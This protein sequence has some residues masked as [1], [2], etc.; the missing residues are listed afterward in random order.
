[1]LALIAGT[2]DLP[3]RIA[4]RLKVWPLVCA[5][6][7]VPP[8]EL[9]PELTFRLETLGSFLQDLADRGVHQVC[10]AGAISRPKVDASQIDMAT[11]PL[12]PRLLAAMAQGDDAALRTVIDIFE[13][14]GFQIVGADAV[15]QDAILPSGIPT[16][17]RPSD[18]DRADA[19]RALS[20]L[21]VLSPLDVGQACVVASGQVLGIEGLGGTDFMLHNFL[22]PNGQ[23]HPRL[24]AE[25]GVL[26]KLPKIGQDRRLDMPTIGVTTIEHVARA[27]LHGIVIEAGGVLVIDATTVMTRADQLGLFI[28]VCEASL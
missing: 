23:R 1:M 24:S 19:E 11:A 20:I 18:Q 13:A 16:Q 7:G 25:G 4:H 9:L 10:F 21:A 28:W 12:V 8:T 6:D 3:T 5:L 14:A 15:L 22:G 26:V 2:G 27:G 17:H